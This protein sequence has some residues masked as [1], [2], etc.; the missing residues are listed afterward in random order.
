MHIIYPCDSPATRVRSNLF[1]K[2]LKIKKK[3]KKPFDFPPFFLGLSL[4]CARQ[5]MPRKKKPTG[6]ESG[7]GNIRQFFQTT[8]P[9]REITNPMIQ[10]PPT[11]T[12]DPR[13]SSTR[14]LKFD[15]IRGGNGAAGRAAS[16]KEQANEDDVAYSG[17]V[18][19]CIAHAHSTF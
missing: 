2:F 17:I 3:Y 16:Q 19:Y 14:S 5:K 4:V 7:V 15:Q 11:S 18:L 8:T 9:L 13:G 1:F 12:P 10:S 6:E